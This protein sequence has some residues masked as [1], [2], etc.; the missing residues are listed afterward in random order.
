MKPTE[1][2]FA[3]SLIEP[4]TGCMTKLL[5]E[6][7]MGDVPLVDPRAFDGLLFFGL[8]EVVGGELRA[9]PRVCHSLRP[10]MSPTFPVHTSLSAT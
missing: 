6:Q 9:R 8:A 2:T 7:Y 3:R 4:L 10:H 1:C 5:H